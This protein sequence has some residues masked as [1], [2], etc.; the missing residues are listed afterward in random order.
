MLDCWRALPEQE[1]LALS[2]RDERL[3]AAVQRLLAYLEEHGGQATS[4]QLLRSA[5]AGCRTRAV[6]NQ[7][8]DHF[9]ATY[10]G[11][12]TDYQPVRGPAAHLVRAPRRERRAASPATVGST[13]SPYADASPEA[14][15]VN[16]D[17]APR[18]NGF[19]DQVAGQGTRQ[20]ESVAADVEPELVPVEVLGS[21]PQEGWP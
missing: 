16:L 13:I 9:E 2:L 19:G 17:G 6:L 7:V 5:V 10:P 8:L 15:E 11:T 1:A 21:E 18:S 14:S 4:R 12:V 20:F 3:G